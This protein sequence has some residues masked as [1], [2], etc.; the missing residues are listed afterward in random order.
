MPI[1]ALILPFFNRMFQDK[2]NETKRTLR[3]KIGGAE[4]IRFNAIGHGSGADNF[5][6]KLWVPRLRRRLTG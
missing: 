6:P 4:I 1:P 2:M 5:L 3:T